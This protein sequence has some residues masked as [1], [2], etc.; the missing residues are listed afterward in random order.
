MGLLS[1]A[2]RV[3]MDAAPLDIGLQHAERSADKFSS[4]LT[5][6]VGGAILGAFTIQR[7]I[8]FGK[9]VI[10][11]G[12]N[13]DR[14]SKKFNLTTTE[15]QLLQ[16]EAKRTGQSFEDL[17]KNADQLESTLSRIRGGDVIF[18]RQMVEQL[19]NADEIIQEFKNQAGLNLA[20][21]I[22]QPGAFFKRL[23]AF[24]NAPL[25]RR[26]GVDQGGAG[27]ANQNQDAFLEK[28]AA[29][30]RAD[31]AR[32]KRLADDKEKALA[33]EKE[34]AEVIERSRVSQLTKEQRL[35]EL[36]QKRLTLQFDWKDMI[37]LEAEATKE[38]AIA[39]NEAEIAS[40]QSQISKTQTARGLSPLSDS[41][42]SVGRFGGENPNN[43]AVQRLSNIERAVKDLHQTIK[44]RTSSESFFPL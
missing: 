44:N 4:R 24:G 3:S 38:L 19:K 15:V 27:E 18:G 23:L 36:L 29:A 40:L 22:E 5:K 34:T 32:V 35:S 1:L 8:G 42:R 26:F 25:A 16:Q 33:I 30:R 37:S 6:Q 14:L 31:A 7:L 43:P 21:A 12:V 39:R 41:L 10:E 9:E 20:T 17:V 28:E 11:Q 13:I 2:G